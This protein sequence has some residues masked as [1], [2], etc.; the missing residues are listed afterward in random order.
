MEGY[1][2]DKYLSNLRVQELSM[3]RRH[4]FELRSV[5]KKT[6]VSTDDEKPL[7]MG[8][9]DYI[10]L[11]MPTYLVSKRNL[12]SI[13][14]Y[15]FFCDYRWS[16]LEMAG[17]R[18]KNDTF[19]IGK[20]L[21]CDA[22]GTPLFVPTIKY[23]FNG[24]VESLNIYIHSKV[25]EQNTYISRVIFK[26]FIPVLAVKKFNMWNLGIPVVNGRQKANII[27]SDINKFYKVPKLHSMSSMLTT[28]F[29]ALV[30]NNL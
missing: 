9:R 25:V 16:G 5:F 1:T 12:K 28:D 4:S 10:P 27:I 22:D 6:L 17:I 7:C 26:Q 24:K 23:S 19:Y 20:N 15:P 29:G 21:I 8:M 30:A 14:K 11:I 13:L 3:R 18:T 2:V